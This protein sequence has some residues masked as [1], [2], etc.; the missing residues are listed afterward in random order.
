MA[1]TTGTNASSKTVPTLL[2]TEKASNVVDAANAFLATLSAPQKTTAGTKLTS[3]LAARWSNF[4]VGIAGRNGLFFRDLNTQQ[5]AAALKVAQLALSKEG[6]ARFQELRAADDVL[7]KAGGRGGPDGGFGGPGGGPGG[8]GAGGGPDGG[9]FD[10]GPDGMGDGPEGGPGGFDGPFEGGGPPDDF[11]GPGGGFD[12]P[13]G[14]F[15]GGPGGG[16]GGP[17]DGFGDPDGGFGGPGGFGGGGGFGGQGGFGGPGGNEYSAANYMI[18]FLGT[19]S[20]TT[21]WMLQLG[22]HHLAFNVY[23]KGKVGASTPYFVGVEPT[24][25]KDADGKTHAPLAPMRDAMY[26]LVNSLTPEQLKQARLNARFSDVYVGPGRDGRFP[27]RE[28]VPVAALSPASKNWVKGAIAA[29]TGDSAQADKYRKLYESELD[30]TKVA[31]SGTTTFNNQ[32]DYV[33]IDGPHV[34]IEFVCQNGI[35]IRNQIHYHTIWR[36][37][38]TDYGAEFSF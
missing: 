13:D 27:A 12:G 24:T 11:D 9:G 15:G 10:G 7:G 37:H 26:N 23:Y 25:W 1:P 35:V 4:P 6:F 20:Q 19:P 34:W 22:G 30:Q 31:Y 8:G 33:R 3:R 38:V 2:P 36:D 5:V 28:G 17:D 32:G 14:G 16:F 29:W 18:A 21:P